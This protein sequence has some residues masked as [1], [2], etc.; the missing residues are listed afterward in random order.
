M[1]VEVHTLQVNA[2]DLISIMRVVLDFLRQLDE[3]LLE[4]LQKYLIVIIKANGE[5]IM[6]IFDSEAY[7]FMVVDVD[8]TSCQEV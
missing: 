1:L 8:I 6:G 7:V 2:E 3:S 5:L 4:Q